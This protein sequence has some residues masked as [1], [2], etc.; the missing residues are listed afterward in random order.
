M[1][2]RASEIHWR[3]IRRPKRV[4]HD[5]HMV[6]DRPHSSDA[7][8]GLYRLAYDGLRRDDAAEF[9]HPIKRVHMDIKQFQGRSVQ[10]RR[11]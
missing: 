8:S 10:N 3:I 7:A 9:D 5:L 2:G 4:L 11:R 1:Q 6:L